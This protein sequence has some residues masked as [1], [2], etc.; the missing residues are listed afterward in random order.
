SALDRSWGRFGAATISVIDTAT[1]ERT[2]VV[3][4]ADD[5]DVRRSPDGKYI[6]FYID[7]QFST[8]DTA[9]RTVTN[10]TRGVPASFADRESDSTD[11]QRPWFGIGGGA[12]RA[13]TA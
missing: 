1:G 13:R 11:V 2:K 5:R 4:R 3:D 12:A 7:G 8:I 9:R 6:L 10:I